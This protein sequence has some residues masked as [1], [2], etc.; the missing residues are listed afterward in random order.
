MHGLRHTYASMLIMLGR[1]ILK[2]S[3]Y[4][5]HK[6]VTVTLRVYAHFINLRNNKADAMDD[7]EG[8]VQNA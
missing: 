3:A 1:E 8:L 2:V 6:D 7:L 4:L 5:G